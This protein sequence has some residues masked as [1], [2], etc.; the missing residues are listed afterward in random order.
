MFQPSHSLDRRQRSP[1]EPQD[2]NCVEY[3]AP[4]H[5]AR[6]SGGDMS[7]KLA[8]TYIA[9]NSAGSEMLVNM[10]GEQIYLFDVNNTRTVNELRVPQ[11]MVKRSKNGLN[12]LCHC[13]VR[14][15]KHFSMCFF[16]IYIYIQEMQPF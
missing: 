11:N 2:P 9:F 13:K 15:V 6:D 14:G 4:G 8:A 16:F 10:G 12:S 5:L 7:Y 3:Y 1:P